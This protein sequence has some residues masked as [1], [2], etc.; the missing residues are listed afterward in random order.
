MVKKALLVGCNYPGTQAQL[1]GCGNDVFGF[2]NLLIERFGFLEA[3]INILVDMD[4]RFPKPTGRAVKEALTALVSGANDG[5]VCLFHYSGH[6]TQIPNKTGTEEDSLDE[7]IVPTDMNILVDDDLKMI[8]SRCHPGVRFTMIADCCHSGGVLDGTEVVISGDK[9]GVPNLGG[10][11]SAAFAKRDFSP[12]DLEVNNKELPIGTLCS[13]L[14][15]QT[16][17][18]TNPSNIHL[19]LGSAFGPD[20][21][22]L[23]GRITGLLQQYQASQKP[24]QENTGAGKLVGVLLGLLKMCSSKPQTQ[25]GPL[26]GGAGPAPGGY[27]AG[28][29]PV[30]T[31]TGFAAPADPNR[32]PDRTVLV[33]GCQSFET[34]A[35]A[36]PS[37]NKAKAFGALSNAIQTIVRES[38][39]PLSNRALVT[40]VR[41]Y[42]TKGG[43]TQNPCLECSH[44]MADTPFIC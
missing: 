29:Q 14:Q 12:E 13:I 2:Q 34:S 31:S 20:A 30:P 26:A 8:V 42:L 38:P 44:D 10:I 27:A 1:N 5:D 23:V 15:Q 24:G 3:N 36:C 22:V 43:F 11:L 19:V 41:E 18:T 32:P 37:G 17:Q 25:E 39:Q 9:S 40:A 28:G 21:S 4:S 16:G 7:A 35:D 33:T 6:G